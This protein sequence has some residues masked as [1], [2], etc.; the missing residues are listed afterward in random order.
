MQQSYVK[1]RAL[2]ENEKWL[3]KLSNDFEYRETR[4]TL[5]RC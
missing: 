5:A 2:K 3:K 1:D 4:E